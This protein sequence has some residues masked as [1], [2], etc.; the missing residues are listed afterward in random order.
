M[1]V[2]EQIVIYIDVLFGINFCMDFMVLLIVNRVM[3]CSS[4][5]P[6]LLLSTTLGAVWSVVAVM[7]SGGH[8]LFVSLCT[9]TLV[10]YVM[11]SIMDGNVT[12]VCCSAGKKQFIK[13]FIR[14][15]LKMMLVMIAVAMMLSGGIHLIIY[16]TYAGFLVKNVIINDR[17]LLMFTFISFFLMS[18]FIHILYEKKRIRGTER[19]VKIIICGKTI[20]LNGIVDTGNLLLDFVTGKPVNVVERAYFD[21][22]LNEINNYE[23]LKYHLIPYRTAGSASEM[24]EVVT[25]EYMYIS[26]DKETKAYDNVL[27]G[28]SR[29]QL[30]GNGEYHALING[31]MENI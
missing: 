4:S 25:A 18:V 22:I 30:S 24:M 15:R 28:L 10:T 11:C 7:I 31:Q 27:I 16:Y 17:E 23:K 6:R 20:E 14:C 21:S 29:L 3:K 9:Y 13:H 5:M 8:K 19:K 12:R 26:D 2:M 1:E